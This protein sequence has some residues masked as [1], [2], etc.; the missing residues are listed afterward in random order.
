MTNSALAN[1]L[2]ISGSLE[3]YLQSISNIPILTAEQEQELAYDFY[4]N[5][6]LEA[7]RKLTLSYLR[8]VAHIARNYTGYGLPQ[9]DIIQE[10]NMG[11]MQA[12]KKF[13]PYKGVRLG[14][15]AI[16]WI[17]SAIHEYVVKNFRM[18][19]VATTKSQRKL[20]FNL[21]K[22]KKSLLAL[23]QSEVSALAEQL[24]VSKKDVRIMEERLSSKDCSFDLPETNSDNDIT[25]PANLIQ[26][27]KYS[28]DALCDQELDVQTLTTDVHQIIKQLDGRT[29]DIINSRWFSDTKTTLD[30]LAKKY[31]VSAE[32][33]RQI[34]AQA[35]TK[36]RGLLKA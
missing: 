9:A 19:K 35:L 21:R 17:K 15:F 4:D 24:D 27:S 36:M 16:H 22:Y 25:A 31:Q 3:N 5:G 10:G 11:L 34:E 32:R 23:T 1:S 14:T 28:P 33:I 8:F 6:N 18:M 7:A 26:E 20:F 2:T 29:Q 12:V 30:D 13:N